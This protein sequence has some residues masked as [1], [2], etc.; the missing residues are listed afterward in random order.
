[1]AQEGFSVVVGTGANV[2][3]KY[4]GQPWDEVVFAAERNDDGLSISNEKRHGIQSSYQPNQFGLREVKSL[5]MGRFA[6]LYI[7]N[8]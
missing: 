3:Q 8:W 5:T 2:K 7:Q 1:M 6:G 4:C